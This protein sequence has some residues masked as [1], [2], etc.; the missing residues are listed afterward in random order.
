[1]QEI[2]TI[3]N[4]AAD[5]T[6]TQSLGSNAAISKPAPKKNADFIL[7]VWQF[8]VSPFNSLYNKFDCVHNSLKIFLISVKI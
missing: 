2:L 7:C 1:V 8:T 3:T 6:S 5:T 4:A